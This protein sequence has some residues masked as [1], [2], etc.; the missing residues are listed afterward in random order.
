[1]SYRATPLVAGALLLSALLDARAVGA[2]CTRPAAAAAA[3]GH[4]AASI[5]D[6][7]TLGSKL[8]CQQQIGRATAT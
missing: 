6:R 8:T 2:R 7:R 1:M 5:V 4:N 3:V